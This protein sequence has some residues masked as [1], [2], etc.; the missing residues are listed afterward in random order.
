V[1]HWIAGHPE[2]SAFQATGVPQDEG[3][4]LQDVYPTAADLGGP[5]RFAFGEAGHLTESSPRVSAATGSRLWTAW[6]PYW[7]LAKPVLLEKSPPNLT[8]TRFLQ[9]LFP[10]ESYFLVVIR[11]PIAVAYATRR[12]TR[13]FGWIPPQASRRSPHLQAGLHTL[14]QHWVVAHE[15][16]LAD[17][18]SLRNVRLVR[19]EDLVNDPAGELAAIFGFLGLAPAGAGW[20]V[21]QALNEKYIRRWHERGATRRGRAGLARI[22]DALE[23]RVRPYGYSLL[24]PDHVFPPDERVGTYVGQA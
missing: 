6:A 19:Y 7:D 3:Q 17:A 24:E 15:R 5:G 23:H 22:T 13:R 9:A 10:H 18:A 12:W 8:K 21:K 1:A 16:F 14:L 4:H 20:E 2:V 11:H